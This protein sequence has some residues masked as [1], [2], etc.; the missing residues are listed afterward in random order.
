ML[1]RLTCDLPSLCSIFESEKAN[2]MNVDV[3][4]NTD[5]NGQNVRVYGVTLLKAKLHY[6]ILPANQLPIW[7]NSTS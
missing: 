5:G 7:F 4:D 1:W 6:A 2:D 3:V